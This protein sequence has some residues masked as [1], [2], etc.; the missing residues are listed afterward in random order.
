M[1]Y[2]QF[3]KCSLYMS[4][5]VNVSTVS[6]DYT[7]YNF[8]IA[9]KFVEYSEFMELIKNEHCLFFSN[10]NTT[11]KYVHSLREQE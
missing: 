4:S 3:E 9:N 6:S 1:I 8:T 10:R 5:I 11:R 2:K 7:S